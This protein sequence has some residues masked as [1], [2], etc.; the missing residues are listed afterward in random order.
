MDFTNETLINFTHD[1]DGVITSKTIR[2]DHNWMYLLN[3]FINH[4]EGC[5]F[6]DV[7]KRVAVDTGEFFTPDQQG[8][9]GPTFVSEEDTESKDDG[10]A[11]FSKPA[12]I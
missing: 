6:T 9:Y 3:E 8:W 2:G 11:W 5:G 10:S 12:S 1:Q 4:L 7:R